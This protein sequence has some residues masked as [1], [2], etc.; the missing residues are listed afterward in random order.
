MFI[1]LENWKSRYFFLISNELRFVV[2]ET[3]YK[4]DESSMF[5]VLAFKKRYYL[6]EI[7]F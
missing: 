4:S 6:F 2:L 5:L 7:I 3:I 1:H